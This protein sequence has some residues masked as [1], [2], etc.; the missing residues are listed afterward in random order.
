MAA[1]SK[2]LTTTAALSLTLEGE[3]LLAKELS[4]E[5]REQGVKKQETR[6]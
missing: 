6:K 3:L 5:E 1:G 2:V 4:L